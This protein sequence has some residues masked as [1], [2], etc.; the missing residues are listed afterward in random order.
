MNVEQQLKLLEHMP[1]LAGELSRDCYRL[2]ANK[3]PIFAIQSGLCICSLLASNSRQGHRGARTN[4]FTMGIV[5]SGKGKNDGLRY[6]GQILDKAELAPVKNH[7]LGSKLAITTALKLGCCAS[8]VCWDEIGKYLS[9]MLSDRGSPHMKEICAELLKIY[10]CASES[11]MPPLVSDSKASR[12]NYRFFQPVLTIQ[13]MGTPETLFSS[14][15]SQN[16]SDGLLPRFMY[17]KG[18]DNPEVIEVNREVKISDELIACVRHQSNKLWIRGQGYS[19]DERGIKTIGSPESPTFYPFDAEAWKFYGGLRKHIETSLDPIFAKLQSRVVEQAVKV[20]L[21]IESG[22]AIRM[23]TLHW[24]AT[25][26]QE[27]NRDFID[28]VRDFLADTPFERDCNRVMRFLNQNNPTL[29]GD[30]Y[31]AFPMSERQ[32]EQMLTTLTKAG[33]ISRTDN[34]ITSLETGHLWD[35]RKELTQRPFRG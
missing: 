15:T 19:R 13:G 25:L 10:S 4:L 11:Y 33:R 31:R 16:V 1:G 26:A 29:L 12:D 35:L 9:E 21:A 2:Q 27:T 23:D 7:A 22:P 17:F 28:D 24:A 20:A 6:T 32:I 34:A 5:G 3:Q 8:I 18:L 14:V 30:L